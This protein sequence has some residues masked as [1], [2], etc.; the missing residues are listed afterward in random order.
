MALEALGII[1]ATVVVSLAVQG[2][3]IAVLATKVLAYLSENAQ[4]GGTPLAVAKAHVANETRIVDEKLKA[5]NETRQYRRSA[6][7][8]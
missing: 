5:A 6:M 7:V 1:G 2:A 8:D 4:V 3:V